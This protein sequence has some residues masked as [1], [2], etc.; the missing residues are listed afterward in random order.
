MRRYRGEPCRAALEAGELIGE[1]DF[2]RISVGSAELDRSA[3]LGRCGGC[4][5]GLPQP[6]VRRQVVKAPMPT[7]HATQRRS[8]EGTS[9]IE[10]VISINEPS[11]RHQ[12]ALAG[13]QLDRQRHAVQLKAKLGHVGPQIAGA[14]GEQP[15]GLH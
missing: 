3:S 11:G 12:C 5:D 10:Q 9:A 4:D 8:F 13:G 14:A 15:F 6:P 7:H 2:C 1:G